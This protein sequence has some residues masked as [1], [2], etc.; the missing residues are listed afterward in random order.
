MHKHI[1]INNRKSTQYR[2][3]K[4]KIKFVSLFKTSFSGTKLLSRITYK[5][6]QIHSIISTKKTGVKA[7]YVEYFYN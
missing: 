2:Y 6:T 3:F 1:N 7:V 4:N 5:H